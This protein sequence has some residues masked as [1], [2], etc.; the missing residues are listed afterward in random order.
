M[1]I[2]GGEDKDKKATNR[3]FSLDLSTVTWSNIEHPHIPKPR[4]SHSLV[5]VNNNI[6]VVGG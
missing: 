3:L 4:F 1:F 5:V 2:F 6:L